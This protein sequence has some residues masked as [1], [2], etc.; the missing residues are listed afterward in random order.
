MVIFVGRKVSIMSQT[1]HILYPFLQ[2]V[3]G[4]WRNALFLKCDSERCPYR[5][6]SCEGYL[7][8]ANADGTPLLMPVRYFRLM[9]GETVSA[10]ECRGIVTRQ[11]FEAAFALYIEWHTLS[12]TDCALNQLCPVQTIKEHPPGYRPVDSA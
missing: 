6:V 12:S 11:A 7:L 4:N 9:A 10:D 5:K 1:K 8:T 2:A 3:H